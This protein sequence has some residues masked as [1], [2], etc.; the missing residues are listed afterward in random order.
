MVGPVSMPE[1]R[2]ILHLYGVAGNCDIWPLSEAKPRHRKFLCHDDRCAR[3]RA[4]GT[5]DKQADQSSTFP[6]RFLRSLIDV[7]PP[8]LLASAVQFG[9]VYLV[10]L[11]LNSGCQLAL[12]TGSASCSLD[13]FNSAASF[14]PALT[15]W[16]VAI[17]LSVAIILLIP[18]IWYSLPIL[19]VGVIVYVATLLPAWF[20]T[21][22]FVLGLV[23]I[24][25]GWYKLA[26]KLGIDA[27]SR[28][29]PSDPRLM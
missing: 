7:S 9:F 10:A 8:A 15:F 28:G 25:Y 18:M 2:A 12:G 4:M 19:A 14:L 27:G 3:G 5:E 29:G 13:L 22:F 21:I 20:G 6:R 1:V 23:A 11:A 16:I 17:V 26:R 24:V